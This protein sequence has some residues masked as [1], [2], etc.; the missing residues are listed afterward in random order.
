MRKPGD[1]LGVK[2]GTEGIVA[3]VVKGAG[4]MRKGFDVLVI[5]DQQACKVCPSQLSHFKGAVHEVNWSHAQLVRQFDSGDRNVQ[6][7]MYPV[8]VRAYFASRMIIFLNVLAIGPQPVRIRGLH[9]N[10]R[11]FS[12]S[13][14]MSA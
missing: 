9:G 5:V 1:S 12:F 3:G 7:S 10:G 4:A 8:P 14:S 13:I 6:D 2:N 11:V